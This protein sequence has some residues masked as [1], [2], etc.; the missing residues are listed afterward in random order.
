MF[1]KIKYL[2]IIVVI[3]KSERMKEKKIEDTTP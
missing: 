2:L 3:K 1:R